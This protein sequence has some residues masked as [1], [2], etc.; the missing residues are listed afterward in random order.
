ME[1]RKILSRSSA[2]ALA[3]GILLGASGTAILAGSRGSDRFSDIPAGAYYDEAVGELVDLGI[4][5]G[6]DDG[7]YHPDEAVTRGQIAVLLKRLRDDV[8]GVSTAARRREISSVA[9]SGADSAT[10]E[11]TVER[12]TS[13][14]GAFRFTLGRFSVGENDGQATVSII[15]S[16]GSEGAVTVEFTASQGSATAG[17]D[18]VAATETLSFA[19]NETSR[20]L[21]LTIR[22]DELSEGPESVNLALSSPTGG[23]VLGTPALATLT[24]S[25]DESGS[26]TP[27]TTSATAVASGSSSAAGGSIVFSATAYE[28]SENGGSVAVTVLRKGTVTRAVAVNYA[29]AD[30]TARAS[31]DYTA[32]TGTLNFA[33]NE[34][35]KTFTIPLMD[36]AGIQ[37]NRNLTLKLL[38]PTGG[39]VIGIPGSV[40]LTIADDDIGPFGTGNFRFSASSY[41]A[42]EGDGETLITVHRVGGTVGEASVQYRTSDSS[43]KAGEDYTATSGT[44]TFLPGESKKT[45]AIPLLKDTPSDPDEKVGLSL[46][47]PTG[48]VTLIEPSSAVLTIYE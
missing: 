12:S 45:F 33:E 7:T 41:E 48:G 15:R 37:G 40:T 1:L 36:R 26:T 13:V 3:L 18:Y 47:S 29:T 43:A 30:G 42:G 35:T 44:L 32:A 46:S 27:Q 8:K 11:R 38:S 21:T 24:I 20:Q 31:V 10:Q 23:A 6:F 19:A 25:D 17:E 9:P 14:A 34:T 5:K 4:I 22:N 16:G 39:A 2:L 28:A